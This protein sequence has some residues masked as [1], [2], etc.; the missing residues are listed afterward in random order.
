VFDETRMSDPES[1]ASVD[2]VLRSI[3]QWGAA[4]RLADSAAGPRLADLAAAGLPRPR[5][6]LAVG[7]DGR[8]LRTVLEPVCPVPFVA[9]P[10]GGLPG[11]AGPLDMVVALS[12]ADHDTA[13][14]QA[15]VAEAVRRGCELVLVCP[16]DSA[17]R[18]LAE[19]RGWVLP[20]AAEDA[21]A[22]SIPALRAL[23]TLGLGPDVEPEPVAAA[24][25]RV[26]EECG[27]GSPVD[28][29][30]AKGLALALADRLPVVWGGSP[31]ASRAARRLAEALRAA[32]GVP[33]VAGAADQLVPLLEA[34]PER[35]VFADPFEDGAETAAPP[36][37]L[38]VLDD[39]AASAADVHDL[40]RL[41]EAAAARGVLVHRVVVD[42][43]GDVARFASLLAVGRFA[44]VYLGMG[45]RL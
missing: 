42:D 8:L 41:E 12:T 36:P 13:H 23:H 3:A 6:V 37:V 20:A 39:H 29:N 9:W 32:T 19:G 44:A 18:E 14:E 26:A 5:A 24:L 4:V 28:R 45:V 30:P 10:H 11:W 2:D 16:A 21:L 43:G 25:D 7:Q 40:K 35:D 33:A 31:L 27:P 17:L 34:A 22:A 15:S 1:L 38:V